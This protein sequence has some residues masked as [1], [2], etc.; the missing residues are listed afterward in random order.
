MTGRRF[1]DGTNFWERQ[2]FV[3]LGQ[4]TPVVTSP[5]AVAPTPVVVTPAPSGWRVGT[6]LAGAG[7]L[8]FASEV[9]GLTNVLGIRKYLK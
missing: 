3:S 4:T 2:P 5:V 6:V 9:V 8:F 7:A 1:M